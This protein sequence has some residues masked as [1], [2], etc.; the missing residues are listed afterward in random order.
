MAKFAPGCVAHPAAAWVPQLVRKYLTAV[1]RDLQR[2]SL[3]TTEMT[4]ARWIPSSSCSIAQY[5]LYVLTG[6]LCYSRD[7]SRELHSLSATWRRKLVRLLLCRAFPFSLTF[8]FQFDYF[9]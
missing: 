4:S 9:T 3:W 5:E 1:Q 8:L 7:K 6:I 2:N